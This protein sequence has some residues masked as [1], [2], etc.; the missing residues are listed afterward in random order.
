[1]YVCKREIERKKEKEREREREREREKSERSAECLTGRC[2][3][4]ASLAA[5]AAIASYTQIIRIINLLELLLSSRH[6]ELNTTCMNSS[7]ACAAS[8]ATQRSTRAL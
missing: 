2:S 7:T 3:S 1:V 4:A 8:R 5:T 6:V